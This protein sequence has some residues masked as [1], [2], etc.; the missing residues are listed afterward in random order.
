MSG[1]TSTA[2]SIDM[3]FDDEYISCFTGQA[4]ASM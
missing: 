3:A 2:D 4:S 1:P